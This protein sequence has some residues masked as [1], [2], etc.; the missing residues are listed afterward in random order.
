MECLN[1]TALTRQRD[2]Y[3]SRECKTCSYCHLTAAFPRP[4]VDKP[5]DPVDYFQDYTP[6]CLA[7]RYANDW[8]FDETLNEGEE[9]SFMEYENRVEISRKLYNKLEPLAKLDRVKF[10]ADV[11]KF[12]NM[13]LLN[14]YWHDHNRMDDVVQMEIDISGGHIRITVSNEQLDLHGMNEEKEYWHTVSAGGDESKFPCKVK[15]QDNYWW[16]FMFTHY[17]SDE[18][19]VWGSFDYDSSVGPGHK[20]DALIDLMAW[21]Y[22]NQD[23]IMEQA[24]ATLT[25]A[26]NKRVAALNA[27]KERE[28]HTLELLK[29]VI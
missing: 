24:N 10:V 4:W 9:H 7:C 25:D 1:E 23:F 8:L 13:E 20:G 29:G 5:G 28:Q 27:D 21:L 18:D 19:S 26:E 22:V 3:H 6:H 2:H 14:L 17:S 16:H 11:D 12:K 15:F